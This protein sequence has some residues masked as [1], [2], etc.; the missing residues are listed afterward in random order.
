MVFQSFNLF[1]HMS[2]LDNVMSGPLYAFGAAARTSQPRAMQL[3]ERVG[4][5]DKSTLD[6]PRSRA[7]S[8][9][10]SPSPV[11]WPTSRA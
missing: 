4:M 11:R 3:L 10:A 9:S 1:P 7:A 2:V 5:R 8:S 6:R